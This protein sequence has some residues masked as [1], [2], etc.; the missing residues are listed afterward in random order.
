M[1]KK[2]SLVLLIVGILVILIVVVGAT[3][4]YFQSNNGNTTIA[5]INATTGTVDSLT[6]G[7]LD[8]NVTINENMDSVKDNIIDNDNVSNNIIINANESNFNNNAGTSLG[9][10][11]TGTAI[12]IAGDDD[13]KAEGTYNVYLYISKNELQ[14][15]SYKKDT[16]DDPDTGKNVLTYINEEEK[17]K[18]TA[19]ELNGYS[20]IPELYLT[21]KK[22]DTE[23]NSGVTINGEDLSYTGGLF[24]DPD[25]TD[26]TA[27]T[28]GGFDI[29]EAEGLI[30]IRVNE[31]IKVEGDAG[32]HTTTD[33]WQIIVTYKNLE[34]NQNL[35]TGKS[36]TGQV[37][38]Q[39]EEKVLTLADFCTGEKIS[40][41]F[42]E[43]YK[44]DENI[45][46]HNTDLEGGAMDDS[47]RYSGSDEE[48][49]NYVCLDGKTAPTTTGPCDNGDADLYRI[50]G[51]FK[52]DSGQYE[53]KLIKYDY[54][55]SAQLGEEGAY[56][57]AYNYGDTNKYKG[58]QDNID[59]IG[60]Y[61]WT[62]HYNNVNEWAGST[63]EE[64]GSELRKTNLN[65]YYL[66]TYL[67][68]EKGIDTDN[69]ITTHT[70]SLNGHSTSSVT[71]K[72]MYDNEMDK[73]ESSP[74][75][76][77]KTKTYPDKIGLMYVSDY[78]YAASPSSTSN[79]TTN[80]NKYD[81][82]T[83]SNW[84]H[85]GLYEWTISRISLEFD[86]AF[87]VHSGGNVSDG[88]VGGF[89]HGVRPSFYLSSEVQIKS[90]DGSYDSPYRLTI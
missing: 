47:Y 65:T 61:Y 50:I 20:P 89:Q 5:N 8:K 19:E 11:I 26:K 10:G 44:I 21:I 46:F 73:V 33:T 62:K 55:T 6:F 43:N 87:A 4:A 85:R 52:N 9:D 51:L 83:N 63:L 57:S 41:C 68:E 40:E 14:Y 54:A 86:T 48:V 42:P 70:W 60:G 78:G 77:T 72:E 58:N 88:F 82:V 90:G 64:V 66:D 30:K 7:V 17:S 27:K 28:L 67:K 34:Y 69:L 81:S 53:M 38:I 36:L 32:N 80:V 29:T 2:K 75:V 3:Y 13:Y 45:Y 74:S 23:I 71:P 56:V 18:A 12:L 35:N 84:M 59:N 15:S 79:W 16:P 39:K 37:I 22:G 76:P 1:N 31:E 49:K 25:A 24:G